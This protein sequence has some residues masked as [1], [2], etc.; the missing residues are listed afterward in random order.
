MDIVNP[1]SQN[2]Q[3]IYSTIPA[4]ISFNSI[5]DFA[6]SVLMSLDAIAPVIS[7]VTGSI[8]LTHGYEQ[9]HH[10]DLS[11]EP[12]DARDNRRQAQ[13][14]MAFGI[15]LIGYTIYRASPV[16]QNSLQ[17]ACQYN[18]SNCQKNVRDTRAW[19]DQ[20]CSS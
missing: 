8:L 2:I 5:S 1:T 3:T 14:R 12:D 10:A 18:L 15:F 16:Y 4:R 17:A 11:L 20:F 9:F 7:G 19:I 6:I 13:I